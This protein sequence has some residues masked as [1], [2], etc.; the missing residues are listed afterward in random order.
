[1][2]YG[3]RIAKVEAVVESHKEQL[4]RIEQE[5]VR[6]REHTDR[7]FAELRAS[8]DALR[9]EMGNS[10]RWQIRLTITLFIAVVGLFMAVLGMLA[11]FGGML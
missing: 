11:R 1:M 7:G 2:D 8:I 9:C 10:L 4:N 3:E 6:L 5:L